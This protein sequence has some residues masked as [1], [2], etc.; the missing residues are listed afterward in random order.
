MND[1][2][3]S[4]AILLGAAG[5]AWIRTAGEDDVEP[6]AD[7]FGRLSCP[8]RYSRFMGSVGNL[9]KIARDCLMPSCRGDFFTLL[10]E[11]CAHGRRA[12]IAEASYGFD[13]AEGRGEFAISVSDPF[14]H[15][16]LGSACSMRCSRARSVLV[17]AVCSARR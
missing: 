12:V 16:G 10:A 17:A 11:R 1:V 6:L 3:W 13:R 4:N 8:A 9:S 15:H 14:Q 2:L 5:T 7:Y